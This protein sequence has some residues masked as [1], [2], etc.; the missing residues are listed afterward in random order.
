MVIELES[1]PTNVELLTGNF[2]GIT[3]RKIYLNEVWQCFQSTFLVCIV[4][5]HNQ[6]NSSIRP[7]K[8]DLAFARQEY[9][10]AE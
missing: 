1:M 9:M 4:N 10:W 8:L 2:G 5:F 3:H 7:V 6:I